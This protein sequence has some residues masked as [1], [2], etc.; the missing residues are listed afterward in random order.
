MPHYERYDSVQ[1][2]KS[3]AKKARAK[4]RKEDVEESFIKFI[5]NKTSK[6]TGIVIETRYNESIILYNGKLITARLKKR[7]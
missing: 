3:K 7:Y 4:S 2:K 5:I 1:I 6:A